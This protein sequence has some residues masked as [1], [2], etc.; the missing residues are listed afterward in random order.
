MATTTVIP[1]VV[2]QLKT[3]IASAC[4]SLTYEG[5]APQV[6]D[7][8][9]A[10][11][12]GADYVV[13]GD[14]LEGNHSYPVMKAGRKPREESYRQHVQI[15]CTRG[16]GESTAART[17]ALAMMNT[18]ENMIANDP[19]IGLSATIPTLRLEILKFSMNTTHEASLMGWRVVITLEVLV[20]AR[21]V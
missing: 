19:S 3:L 20:H 2:A 17:A 21:L 4:A 6:F 10:A 16:G 5:V 12:A 18:V 7:S 9:P 8:Y 14:I 1:T 15:F 11:I 13:L